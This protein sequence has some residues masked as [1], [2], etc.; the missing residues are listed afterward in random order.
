MD[1]LPDADMA[2]HAAAPLGHA[3]GLGR[4]GR[5]ALVHGGLGDELGGEDRSLT[6][7]AG[8]NMIV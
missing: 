4:A 2:D 3:D 1:L 7:D 5:E 6:A 8:Q